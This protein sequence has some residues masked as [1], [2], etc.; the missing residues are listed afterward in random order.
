MPTSDRCAKW[1]MPRLVCLAKS[2][3]PGLPYETNLSEC[4]FSA[5]AQGRAD[6]INALRQLQAI[7]NLLKQLQGPFT[8]ID[9]LVLPDGVLARP[10]K[11]GEV[12][13]VQRGQQTNTAYF[14]NMT[15]QTCLQALPAKVSYLTVC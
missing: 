3:V 10:V 1:Y 15:S 11:E 9:D 4:A 2:C 5:L 13:I 14:V 7:S 12:R 8:S 6:R